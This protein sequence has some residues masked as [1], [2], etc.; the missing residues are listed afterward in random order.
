MLKSHFWWNSKFLK[1]SYIENN[2]SESVSFIALAVFHVSSDTT[3]SPLFKQY[4][5]VSLF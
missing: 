3:R 1:L 2:L 4:N 5:H